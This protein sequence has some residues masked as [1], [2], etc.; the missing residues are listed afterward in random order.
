MRQLISS[1]S[2]FFLFFFFPPACLE[3]GNLLYSSVKKSNTGFIPDG[4]RDVTVN[5]CIT[6]TD[7]IC[8]ALALAWLWVTGN[9]SI[10]RP[11]GITVAWAA[12]LGIPLS[13][14]IES[15]L[16]LIAPSARHMSL[17]ITLASDL[18]KIQ[19]FVE[20]WTYLF[21][22]NLLIR[23]KTGREG[24][25]KKNFKCETDKKVIRHF[26]FWLTH[27]GELQ[28]GACREPNENKAHRDQEEMTKGEGEWSIKHHI[29]KSKY[30][31]VETENSKGPAVNLVFNLHLPVSF[32]SFPPGSKL[33]LCKPG[34]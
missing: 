17:T 32:F 9:I 29:K 8:F 3:Q 1:K 33:A 11:R 28:Q 26:F 23:S 4:D 12:A 22:D 34:A 16:A 13:Q 6:R 14:V 5:F 7:D 21:L 2:V 30:S 20:W 18:E 10:H 19:H 27:T 24:E 15:I 25:E 31:L